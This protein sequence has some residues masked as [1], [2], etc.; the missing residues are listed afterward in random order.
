[1]PRIIETSF[2]RISVLR[3]GYLTTPGYKSSGSMI[4]KEIN[5]ESIKEFIIYLPRALQ[6]GFLAPF[7]NE[8]F[9]QANSPGGKIMKL[10]AGLEMSLV[11]ISLIF[12][13]YG[14][15]RWRFSLEFWL[16]IIF[17]GVINLIYS[18]ATPNLG[19]LYRLRYGFIMLMVAIG[20]ASAWL[21][22]KNMIK[23]FNQNR[24]ISV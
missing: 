9:S 20:V 6:I 2:L 16:A 17:S 7:P 11:Y 21:A 19:S 1:M 8:W 4:D 23:F 15:W 5:L 18:Y 14:F 22:V 24:K 13:P 10:V 12:L 3:Q